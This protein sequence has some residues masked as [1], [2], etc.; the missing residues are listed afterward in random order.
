VH[1]FNAYD[2]IFTDMNSQKMGYRL[3]GKRH[4]FALPS[5]M[6]A[7]LVMIAIL[8]VT[9]TSMT[10]VRTSLKNQYYGQLAQLAGEAGIEY[11]K[12]CLTA[13]NGVPQWT[14]TVLSANTDCT[15]TAYVDCPTT[16]TDSRCSV[17]KNGNIRTNF[18]VAFPALDSSGKA[19]TL[20][21]NGYTEL[22][23]TSSS[24]VW[25]TYSQAAQQFKYS[26]PSN[27]VVSGGTLYS[28]SNYY[29]RLF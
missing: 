16:S 26:P 9:V 28:D 17:L 1:I 8:L 13:N 4:G 3:F 21:A 19:V 10:A 12:S 20:N 5:V 15:G 27:S 6:I 2:I 11:A 23:R 25:K 18:S 29:Y 7:S 24:Q 14:G 22:L